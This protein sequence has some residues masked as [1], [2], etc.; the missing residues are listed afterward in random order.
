MMYIICIYIYIYVYIY[1][2]VYIYINSYIYIYIILLSVSYMVFTYRY[3]LLY[4]IFLLFLGMVIFIGVSTP[5][6]WWVVVCRR[7]SPKTGAWLNL[8]IHIQ[9]THIIIYHKSYIID[10]ILYICFYKLYHIERSYFAIIQIL[11]WG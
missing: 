5:C 7:I 1:K 3:Y 8:N 11:I 9:Y 4:S 6:D 2:Y 10:Y